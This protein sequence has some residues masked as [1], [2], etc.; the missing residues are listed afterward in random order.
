L[1]NIGLSIEPSKHSIVQTYINELLSSFCTD[2]NLNHAYLEEILFSNTF[3][4]VEFNKIIPDENDESFINKHFYP[5]VFPEIKKHENNRLDFH[6]KFCV[7]LDIELTPLISANGVKYGS[8]LLGNKP[9]LY[10]I[11]VDTQQV[12]KRIKQ[13]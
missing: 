1:Y 8:L 7:T 12:I 9:V 3:T 10:Y 5:K 13:S 4:D 11:Y 2:L 6:V